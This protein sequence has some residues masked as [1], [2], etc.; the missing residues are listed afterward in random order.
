MSNQNK[1]S[2]YVNV[3]FKQFFKDVEANISYS[4]AI[5][6]IDKEPYVT[7]AK[8][9]TTENVDGDNEEA[10]V[11]WHSLPIPMKAFSLFFKEID[12]FKFQFSHYYNMSGKITSMLPT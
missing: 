6:S 1:K 8:R 10:K 9:R 3:F 11:D 5:T 2:D 4:F 12:Y 7:F